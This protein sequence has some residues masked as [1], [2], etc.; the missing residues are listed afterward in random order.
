MLQGHE[1]APPQDSRKQCQHLPHT[2][3]DCLWIC[4]TALGCASHW[5]SSEHAFYSEMGRC[6]QRLALTC[7][8]RCR[9]LCMHRP[10][11]ATTLPCWCLSYQSL[12]HLQQ[13][14]CPQQQQRWWMHEELEEE[15][16]QEPVPV[17]AFQYQHQVPLSQLLLI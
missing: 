6:H 4:S 5:N 1:H 12:R 9:D 14:R 11:C 13:A 2:R 10:L 16:E 8:P 15:G 7:T 3:T 17:L